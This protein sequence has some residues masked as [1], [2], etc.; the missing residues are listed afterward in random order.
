MMKCIVVGN[1]M[2]TF[3]SVEMLK[4]Y[5]LTCWNF[6]EVHG[7]RKVGSPCSGSLGPQVK[8]L[9]SGLTLSRSVVGN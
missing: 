9:A 7:K 5:I 3:A 1:F 2:G 8:Q 6:E 4:G